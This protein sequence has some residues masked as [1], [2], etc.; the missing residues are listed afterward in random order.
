[1]S[2]Q[3]DDLRRESRNFS[4]KSI[5]IR[6]KNASRNNQIETHSCSSQ[7]VSAGGLKLISHCPLELDS[8]LDVEIDLGSL[9]AVIDVKAEVKWCL[10]ID[11]APTYY[12]GIKL[13]NIE[14]SNRQV[15][16]KFIQSLKRL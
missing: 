14:K 8:V 12:I 11:A 6:Y 10:E 13:V 5:T 7:D 3:L 1:M 15:W 9:W 4:E 2:V 16:S